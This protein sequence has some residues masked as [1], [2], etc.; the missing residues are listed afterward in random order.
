VV[1][2]CS[3]V[4][5]SYSSKGVGG[6]VAENTPPSIPK[7]SRTQNPNPPPL[8]RAQQMQKMLQHTAG[9]VRTSGMLRVSSQGDL[10]GTNS[11]LSSPIAGL[12]PLQAQV[13][14]N[15]QTHVSCEYSS[16][17][18]RTDL[19]P[20]ARFFASS[21]ARENREPTCASHCLPPSA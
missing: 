5:L 4:A 6:D 21:L 12:V 1:L 18:A 13:C 2:G 10:H 17:H 15:N 14:D 20:Q 11:L 3:L 7:T 19:S 8:P 9:T 16:S